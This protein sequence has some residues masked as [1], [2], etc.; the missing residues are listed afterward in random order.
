VIK[1]NSVVATYNV[2]ATPREVAYDPVFDRVYVSNYDGASISVFSAEPP[3]ADFVG[4]PRSGTAPLGV[5][6]TGTLTGVVTVYRWNFGDGGASTSTLNPSH[7]YNSAGS[8]GVALI[9]TGPGGTLQQMKANYITVNPPTGAPTATF[10]ATPLSGKGPLVVTFTAT[11]SGTVDTMLWSFD[12]GTTST[13]SPT[14][15][16][17]YSYRA[18]GFAPNLVVSNTFGA[19]TYATLAGYILVEPYKVF[20]PL[21][22]R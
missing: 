17:T 12:D 20:L 9:I 18:G 15:V 6:F 5:Q 4:A 3:E 8:F 1:D 14:V 2:G 19:Y 7:I 16:H 11:T 22:R 13:I 10:L 21:I